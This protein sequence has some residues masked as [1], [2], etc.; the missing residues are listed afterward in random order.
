MDQTTLAY[1]LTAY[2]ESRGYEISRDPGTVNIVYLEG[3]DFDGT[4]NRD[5]IDEWNDRRIVLVFDVQGKPSIIHNV[6]ATT[7]PGLSATLSEAARRR[8]GCAR[9]AIGQ[10]KAWR[11]GSHKRPDHPALVQVAPIPVHRDYNRDGKRTGDRVETGLFG[12]NQH[13]TRANIRPTKVGFW[14]EGCLVAR[15][16]ADHLAFVQLC[17]EDRRYFAD[18]NFIF[19]ATVIDGDDFGRFSFTV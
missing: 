11:L 6:P 17:R 16:W 15:I 12:I 18:A 4:P 10:Y 19:S 5:T 3:S 9:I 14:S 2:M 7:E 1:K 8:G 13:G